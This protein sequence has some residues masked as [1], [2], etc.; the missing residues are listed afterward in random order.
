MILQ[1]L[2]VLGAVALLAIAPR[3]FPTS[4]LRWDAVWY[5]LIRAHDYSY[6]PGVMSSTAF[7]PLFPLLWRFTHLGNIGISLLNLG[8][9]GSTLYYLQRRL[10]LRWA[11][12]LL[13]AAFPSS[14]FLYLP[15]PEALFFVF[16]SLIALALSVPRPHSAALAPALFGGA[17]V[18]V[19]AFCYLPALAVVEA[20]GWLEAPHT[21]GR[22]AW[23]LFRY[24]LIT[25]AGLFSVVVYQWYQT[26]VWFAFN[27][28]EAVWDHHFRLPQPPFNSSQDN[29]GA[30]WIDGLA[31]L[32]GLAALLWVGQALVLVARRKRPAPNQLLLFS[33]TYVAATMLVTVFNA[34]LDRGHSSL[35]SLHRYVFCNPFF[36]VLLERLVPHQA[37][38]WRQVLATLAV[39]A[40]ITALLGM[41]STRPFD[42]E[43]PTS[44]IPLLWGPVP[45]FVYASAVLAYCFL[46][47]KT[48]A[49]WGRA[50]VYL[51]SFG[52]QLFFLYTF[53]VGHWVG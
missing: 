5:D 2:V 7:F 19:T 27:K 29:D 31:L 12:V 35:M 24:G 53:A 49:R 1:A 41:F 39:V 13:F 48:D 33:A 52:L 10:R 21:W 11:V 32:F 36:L 42:I 14:L 51:S 8:L 47:L 40:G 26:G 44:R 22:R 3:P 30:L 6:T 25:G 46:W 45:G 34:P 38:S 23:R 43:W 18:R 50:M 4:L 28:S 20:V 37:L 17:L 9:T 16:S 15:Y